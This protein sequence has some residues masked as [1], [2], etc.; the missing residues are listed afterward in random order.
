MRIRTL[1]A[2]QGWVLALTPVASLMVALDQLVVATALSTIRD[3]LGASI[4]TLEW[5]VN[6]Y[7]LSFAVLLIAGAAMG[8]RFGRRRVFVAR[9]AH[10]RGHRAPTGADPSERL[11]RRRHPR[12]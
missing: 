6:A 2:R 12:P 1:T 11:S 10:L 3:D 4:E 8:D 7:S 9:L 5:T